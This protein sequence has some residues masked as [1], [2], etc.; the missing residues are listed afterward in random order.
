MKDPTVRDLYAK[1]PELN[2]LCFE[3][4]AWRLVDNLPCLIIRGISDYCDSHKNNDWHKYAALT[5]AVY[6]RELIL[7]LSPQDVHCMTPCADRFEVNQGSKRTLE[8]VDAIDE[9]AFFRSYTDQR[10]TYLPILNQLLQGQDEWKSQQLIRDFKNII[11]II[12]ILKSPL[13]VNALCQ[14][15]DIKIARIYTQLNALYSIFNVSD[16]PSIP[17]GIVDHIFLNFLLDDRTKKDRNSE[18]FWIDGGIAHYHLANKCFELMKYR[19]KKNICGLS[20][21]Y[22]RRNNDDKDLINLYLPSELQYAC[23]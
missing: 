1:D 9:R 21:E 10:E 6:A 16:Q 15:L 3:T 4:E 20:D 17:I 18:K 7:V 5:A 23:Q 12:L 22:T 14:L 8:G 19:L 11:G 13:S 2:I